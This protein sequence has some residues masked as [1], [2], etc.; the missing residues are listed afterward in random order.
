MVIDETQFGFIE[1]IYKGKRRI[2]QI[3]R[4]TDSGLI[5]YLAFMGQRDIF[6]SGHTTISE[7]IREGVACWWFSDETIIRLRVKKIDVLAIKV[8]ETG[9]H[10]FIRFSD[11]LKRPDFRLR[12]VS[13]EHYAT[14]RYIPMNRFW[15]VA[16]QVKKLS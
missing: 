1:N 11:A 15:T 12:G 4:H 7:A 8:R 16:G 14:R 10:H 5:F 6:K 13:D 9:D 2:A 3:W